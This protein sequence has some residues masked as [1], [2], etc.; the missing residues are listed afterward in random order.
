M[1]VAEECR[2]EFDFW[3]P[4]A[5]TNLEELLSAFFVLLDEI[6]TSERRIFLSTYYIANLLCLLP[7]QTLINNRI[8]DC[9]PTIDLL[10]RIYK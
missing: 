8:R 5:R 6:M 4:K 2:N 10:D 3:L 9:L 7:Y 1:E